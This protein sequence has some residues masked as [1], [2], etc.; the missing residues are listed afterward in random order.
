MV[1]KNMVFGHAE[2]TVTM[3]VLCVAA[4]ALLDSF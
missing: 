1:L 4:S 3:L 2:L